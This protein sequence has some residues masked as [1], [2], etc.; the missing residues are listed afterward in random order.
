MRGTAWATDVRASTI[1]APSRGG[2][3]EATIAL[4]WALTLKTILEEAGIDTHLIRTSTTDA[5][6]VGGR[7]NEAAA[8]GCTHFISIHCNAG[9]AAANGVETFWR[10]A[11]DKALA[12]AVQDAAL[13]ATGLKSRGLKAESASQHARLAVLYFGPPACLVEIGFLTNARDR[14]RL[15]SRDVRLKFAHELRAYFLRLQ[16]GAR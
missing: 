16:G 9:P 11:E 12:E 13:I 6:P 8:A 2:S 4:A 5:N 15:L 3:A 10:G 7:D 14:E 1:R